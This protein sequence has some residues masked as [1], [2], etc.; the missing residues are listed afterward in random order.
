MKYLFAVV[1]SILST[2]VLGQIG[3]REFYIGSLST[4]IYF[5]ITTY[6]T[7]NEKK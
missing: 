5:A 1:F 6:P 4:M 2:I 3:V 7:S